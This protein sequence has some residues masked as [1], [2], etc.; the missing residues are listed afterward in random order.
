M[1]MIVTDCQRGA[2]EVGSNATLTGLLSV[3]AVVLVPLLSLAP[4]S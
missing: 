1:V 3:P 4:N 2:S